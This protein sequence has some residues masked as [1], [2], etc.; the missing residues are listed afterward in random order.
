MV[1]LSLPARPILLLVAAWVTIP[2]APEPQRNSVTPDHDVVD[3]IEQKN[4]ISSP[5]LAL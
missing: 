5:S 2:L 1:K 4:K 3:D